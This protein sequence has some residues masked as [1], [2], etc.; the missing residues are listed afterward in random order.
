MR[1]KN[2]EKRYQM[3]GNL[4]TQQQNSSDDNSDN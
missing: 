1:D 4:N 3:N 2:A